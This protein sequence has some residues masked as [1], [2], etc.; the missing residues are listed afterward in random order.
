[1]RLGQRSLAAPAADDNSVGRSLHVLVGYSARLSGIQLAAWLATLSALVVASRAPSKPWTRAVA[2]AW[3][4]VLVAGGPPARA[5]ELPTLV[6]QDHRFVPER[7][8]VPAGKKFQLRVRNT[9]STADEFESVDLN[10]E[11]LVPPGQ[12]IA[13]F[14]GPLPP[15]T[16]KFFGDFHQDTAQGVLVAK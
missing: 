9:D 10:R 16:Y 5:D 4:A 11:K 14:L 2:G 15:G 7:M 12:T 13:V 1:M 6:L 8:Q 3:L